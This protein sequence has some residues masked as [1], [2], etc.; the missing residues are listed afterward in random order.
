MN[1]GLGPVHKAS[2]NASGEVEITLTGLYGPPTAANQAFTTRLQA[3]CNE[4]GTTTVAVASGSATIV[5]SYATGEID[6]GDI[7]ALGI[8]LRGWDAR[9][10]LLHEL[11]EQRQKQLGTTAAQRGYG[12]ATTGAHSEGLAAELG[13]VGAV[14]ESDSNLVGATANADGTMNGSRTVVFR[15]PD[16]SRYQVV[17]TLSHNNIT[18]VVRTR[19]P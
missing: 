15:Y 7:E 3:L 9:G 19:L 2:V 1:A 13:V 11:V 10:A 18:N 14:L 6:I 17:V 12:S 4:A 5:G 8:N 16:G